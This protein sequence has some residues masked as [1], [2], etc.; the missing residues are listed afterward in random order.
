MLIEKITTGMVIKN[1]K[2]LCGLL[3]I[4]PK[5]GISKQLQIK[6]FERYCSYKKQGQKFIIDEV[7]DMP[8]E[9]I[10][11]VANGNNSK[12]IDSIRDILTNYLYE[13]RGSD[14]RVLLSFSKLIDIL[15]LANNTYAIANTRKRELSDILKVELKAVYYFYN[16][17]RSE[18]KNIVERALNNLQKRSVIFYNKKMMIVEHTGKYDKSTKRPILKYREA[19]PDE[20]G[21]ILDAQ[22]GA[23]EY[24]GFE[25]FQELFFAGSSKYKEFMK[26]V[27]LELPRDW[28]FFF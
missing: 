2:E 23:L 28:Q 16:N 21:M 3:E 20:I 7:F 6:E 4:V 9:K 26:L 13:N 8:K 22:K 12:Y 18:F 5:G 19:V 25:D 27:K 17:T 1:Y 15:G 10:N 11:L 14:A 24:L